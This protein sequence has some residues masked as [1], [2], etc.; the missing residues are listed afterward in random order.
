LYDLTIAYGAFANG[1][2]KVTPFAITKIETNR[3]KVIYQAPKPKATKAVSYQTAATMT[4]MMKT[5]IASGTGRAAN[6]GVPA[7]A[8]TGTTDDYRDAWFVGF[9][10]DVVTGVWVGN[11]DNSIMGGMT[12]GTVPALI[13]RDV[14]KIAVQKYGNKDYRQ[15]ASDTDRWHSSRLFRKPYNTRRQTCRC[16]NSCICKPGGQGLWYFC[17]KYAEDHGRLGK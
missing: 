8:K 7:A 9:T 3:S 14:M 13:W 16:H 1:G 17:V 5:V 15:S 11:D 6:I 2:F 10:P 12:G 4:A